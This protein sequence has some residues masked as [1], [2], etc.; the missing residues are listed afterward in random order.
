MTAISVIVEKKMDPAAPFDDGEVD[1]AEE[2]IRKD[3]NNS[4]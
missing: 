2:E 4:C 1:T 3:M